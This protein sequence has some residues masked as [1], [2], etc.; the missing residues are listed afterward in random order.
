MAI[1]SDI[2]DQRV[3][4]ALVT[5]SNVPKGYHDSKLW[6]WNFVQEVVRV[7]LMLPWFGT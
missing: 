5:Y 2:A 4:A 6:G 7:V 1:P 3:L